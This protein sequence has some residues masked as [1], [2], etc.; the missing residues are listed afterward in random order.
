[1]YRPDHA[2]HTASTAHNDDRVQFLVV[3]D[4]T[5]L[6]ELEAEL[7][8]LPLCARGRVFVEVAEQSA[9]V[10]LTA[11]IRMTVTWLVRAQ[12]SG[13]PGTA[14]RCAPGEAAV[15]AV[16]AWSAEMLCDGPGRTRAIVTGSWS[17][18]TDVRELLVDE[19]GMD[20]AAI[21]PAPR[22]P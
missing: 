17:L 6:A 21:S 13:R 8:L 10:P 20:A 5:S 1:M 18:E 4:E 11:P 15:R 7:A 12:R 22:L 2:T 9:I 14:A 19:A 3:G 16:R